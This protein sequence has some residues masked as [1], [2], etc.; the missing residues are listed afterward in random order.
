MPI[1]KNI[2]NLKK[3]VPISLD[4]RKPEVMKKGLNEGVK[5]I[6]DVS[7]L[8]YSKDT[9]PLLK[10]T[11]SPIIIMHS[12][13]TP[14]LMQRRINYKNVLIETYDYLEKKLLSV[15]KMVLNGHRLSLIL[16][17]ALVKI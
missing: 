15:K 11:K 1:L 10:K 3:K 14:K 6:N 9:I 13:S 8:R 12:I 2:S 17:L 5:I 4:T 7:G 16:E